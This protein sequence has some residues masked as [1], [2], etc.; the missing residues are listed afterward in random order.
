MAA[1]Q[2][3]DYQQEAVSSVL[4]HFRKTTESAVIVLPTGSGKSLVI[5]ELVCL[6]KRRIL[7]LPH[8]K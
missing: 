8:V 2:L 5:A 7:V 3:R 4:N 6:A 1:F